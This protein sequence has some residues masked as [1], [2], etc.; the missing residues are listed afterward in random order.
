MKQKKL[1]CQTCFNE[2]KVT[3]YQNAGFSYV[4]P[5]YKIACPTCR[6]PTKK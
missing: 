4:G 5:P 6:R 2:R 1:I 3:I